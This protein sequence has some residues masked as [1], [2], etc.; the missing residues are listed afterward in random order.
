MPAGP[1]NPIEEGKLESSLSDAVLYLLEVRQE[2]LGEA[3]S[4]ASRRGDTDWTHRLRS[5]VD[6]VSRLLQQLRACRERE[7]VSGLHL[8]EP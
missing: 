2:Q 5:E 8:R 6:N 7:D 1:E 3:L 4:E